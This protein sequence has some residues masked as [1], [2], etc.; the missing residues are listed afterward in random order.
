MWHP[1]AWH[2]RAIRESFLHKIVFFSY[3]R[4]FSP[5][6]VSRYM[7]VMMSLVP[8]L[9]YLQCLIGSRMKI[10]RENLVRCS[11]NT[12]Y[13]DTRNWRLNIFR[14]VSI[15]L[16]FGA[17]RTDQR[18]NYNGRILPPPPSFPSSSTLC[19]PDVTSYICILEVWSDL[20]HKAT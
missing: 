3:S 11:N 5:S 1:L 20:I 13:I 6:K 19:L 15:Q 7:V 18:G 14:G 10:R 12:R 9:H 17:H 4:E 2:K 8:T 16:L